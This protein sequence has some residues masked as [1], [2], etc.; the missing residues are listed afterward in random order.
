VAAVLGQ[1]LVNTLGIQV[2]QFHG[3][4][5]PKSLLIVA[6]FILFHYALALALVAWIMAGEKRRFLLDEHKRAAETARGF[7]QVVRAH[8][9]DLM[10]HLQ[11]LAAL[12]QTG[13]EDI[14]RE[15]LARII[16]VTI[17]TNEGVQ[18]GDPI[19]A[20]FFQARA[21]QASEQDVDFQLD[22]RSVLGPLPVS[23]AQSLVSILGNLLDNAFEAVALLPVGQR[24]V[25]CTMEPY[26]K[27]LVIRVIDSG[28]GIA[29]EHRERIFE[30][31]FTTKGD[32]RGLGLA[33][34]RQVVTGNGGR[35]ELAQ[36]PTTF[37][38]WFPLPEVVL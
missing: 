36:N 21:H 27:G 4:L 10:N 7:L 37:T 15:Y 20:A 25:I 11:A 13:R 9:H 3:L 6:V 8:R 22:V 28:P 2:L 38:V 17:N 14:G 33:L 24:T 12:F 29:P 34:V 23:T 16:Q 35:M 19:L 5:G 31:G 30:S 18:C 32:G 26:D 1:L